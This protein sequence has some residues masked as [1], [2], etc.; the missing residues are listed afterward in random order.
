MYHPGIRRPNIYTGAAAFPWANPI[1][2]ILWRSTIMQSTTAKVKGTIYYKTSQRDDPIEI[3]LLLWKG[4]LQWLVKCLIVFWRIHVQKM[5]TRVC[6]PFMV[7]LL[8]WHDKQPHSWYDAVQHLENTPT[9]TSDAEE[10]FLHNIVL[11]FIGSAECK[12]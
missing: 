8:V 6:N 12:V 1:R 9:T 7:S 3:S 10:I 2:I 4:K 5:S 11:L